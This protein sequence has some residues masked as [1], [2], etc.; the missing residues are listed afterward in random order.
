M[1]AGLNLRLGRIVANKFVSL[2][3]VLRVGLQPPVSCDRAPMDR[4]V[5]TGT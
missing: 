4:L 1:S 5:G 3:V 2:S